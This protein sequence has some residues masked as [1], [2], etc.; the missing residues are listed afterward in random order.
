MH[1]DRGS[2][3]LLPRYSL[4]DEKIFVSVSVECSVLCVSLAWKLS[5]V[6]TTAAGRVLGHLTEAELPVS[7][8]LSV[9]VNS[10]HFHSLASVVDVVGDVVED[11]FVVFGVSVGVEDGSAVSVSSQCSSQ[12][13]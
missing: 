9:Q 4:S 1:S 10:L 5:L 7:S 11:E 2:L 13:C 3:C 8:V 12:I 6:P